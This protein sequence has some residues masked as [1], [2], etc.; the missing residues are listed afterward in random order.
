[1]EGMIELKEYNKYADLLNELNIVCVRKVVNGKPK[2][3]TSISNA[4]LLDKYNIPYKYKR[5]GRNAKNSR[6]LRKKSRN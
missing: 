1:M 4:E 2:I 5:G 3:Y 6:V